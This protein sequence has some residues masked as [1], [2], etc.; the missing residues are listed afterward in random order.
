MGLNSS[1]R[2]LAFTSVYDL[3]QMI[4]GKKLSPVEL[5]KAIFRRI[6]SLNPKLNAFLTLAEQEAMD[7]AKKAEELLGKGIDLG[8]LHGMPVGIKDLYNTKGIRTTYGSAVYKDNVPE[9]DGILPRRLKAAGAIIVGKTNVPEYGCANSTENK[10]GDSCRNPWNVE[11]TSGGSSG[12]AAASVASGMCPICPGSDGGGSVRIPSGFCGV[13]GLKPTYGR[14]PYDIDPVYGAGIDFICHGPMTRNVRDAAFLLEIMSGPDQEDYNSIN[15]KPPA[16]L[17][18]IDEK[19]P[20][21][22][23]A[24]SPDMGY[25]E[26]DP[27]VSSIVEASVRVFKEMGHKVE[28]A[29]PPI[30]PPFREWEIITSAQNDLTMGYHLDEHPDMLMPYFKRSL[31]IGLK[32]RGADVINSFI[33]VGR[34]RAKMREFFKTYDLFLSPTNA[35][36]AFPIGA[37]GKQLA[38]GMVE[39]SFTPFTL[40]FNFTHHP[41]ASVPCG[42]T[43]EGLPVGLQIAGRLE[44]EETI[45]KASYAFEKMK[46]WAG[47]RPP[48]S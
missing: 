21:L 13:Y 39:W 46:P 23:I 34:W 3:A 5:M 47:N 6:D 17:K 48:V 38:D 22:N 45:L 31:E 10:L 44:D 14:I 25:A 24:W 36:G 35:V 19:L 2:E 12:G 43:S 37:K 41:A 27:Q 42:F 11:R 40:I 15:K 20:Q 16:F 18:L 8:P 7:S 26:V 9:E 1:D 4:K 32:A 33:E 30:D 29:A 28:V